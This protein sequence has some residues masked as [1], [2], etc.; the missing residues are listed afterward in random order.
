[1]SFQM[2]CYLHNVIIKNNSSLP[3]IQPIQPIKVT[4]ILGTT[5]IKDIPKSLFVL[6]TIFQWVHQIQPNPWTSKS[7]GSKSFS[8][9][10]EFLLEFDWT[11]IVLVISATSQNIDDRVS[12][13][14]NFSSHTIWH[15]WRCLE[16]FKHVCRR[17]S[18][19]AR[20]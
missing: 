1:M 6:V 3:F 17:A 9:I 18:I 11:E 19:I 16:C 12:R 5:H 14:S 7:Y 20:K 10:T 15:F 2:I 8:T 13:R 4:I